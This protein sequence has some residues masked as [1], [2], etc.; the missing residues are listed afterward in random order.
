M[1]F[2]QINFNL[3]LCEYVKYVAMLYCENNLALFSL[4]FAC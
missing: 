1:N 3:Y 2:T 4:D